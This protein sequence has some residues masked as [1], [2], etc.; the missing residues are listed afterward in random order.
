[1]VTRHFCAQTMIQ[2]TKHRELQKREQRRRWVTGGANCGSLL[3]ISGCNCISFSCNISFHD[4]EFVGKLAWSEGVQL[5]SLIQ[6][7][8]LLTICQSLCIL[9]DGFLLQ[10]PLHLV[11]LLKSFSVF[12][13]QMNSDTSHQTRVKGKEQV[14]STQLVMGFL[15]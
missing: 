2:M 5:T 13:F 15:I 8:V 7:N 11:F 14:Q 10:L 3:F 12:V 4:N 9:C 6:L 1:M